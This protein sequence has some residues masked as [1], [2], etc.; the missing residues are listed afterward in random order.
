MKTEISIQ[1]LTRDNAVV[2][3]TKIQ[4][5]G[6]RRKPHLLIFE[7]SKK[8]R[9]TLQEN[10]DEIITE[11]KANSQEDYVDYTKSLRKAIMDVFGKTPT[12]AD[13]EPPKKE[14]KNNE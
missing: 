1:N 12:V 6:E 14:S 5:D 2:R 8:G 10:F 4:D 13:P 7:N 3:T 9:E 11:L